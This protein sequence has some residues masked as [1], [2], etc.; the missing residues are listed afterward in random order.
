MR[1]QHYYAP[2]PSLRL[3]G[4][5]PLK[6]QRTGILYNH[7]QNKARYS[8]VQTCDNSLCVSCYFKKRGEVAEIVTKA[9]QIAK[10]RNDY[11]AFLTLTMPTMK[12]ES[13]FQAITKAWNVVNINI[14]RFF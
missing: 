7:S 11:A 1:L 6:S 3:C 5:V 2:T 8:G 13:Q 12:V 10:R 4:C 9:L 14:R